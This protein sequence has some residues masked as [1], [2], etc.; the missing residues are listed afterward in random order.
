MRDLFGDEVREEPAYQSARSEPQG[1]MFDFPVTLPGQ[2]ALDATE[3]AS[4][5]KDDLRFYMDSLHVRR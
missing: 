5:V 1:R 3:G 4:D 2:M